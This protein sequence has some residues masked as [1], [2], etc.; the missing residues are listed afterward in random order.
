MGLSNLKKT[1][2]KREYIIILT[3]QR[4]RIGRLGSGGDRPGLPYG[5]AVI[6][7]AR[8]LLVTL[9]RR[10]LR[11]GVLNKK[12]MGK[13]MFPKL[14]CF[15]HYFKE[16]NLVTQQLAQSFWVWI[17]RANR[18]GLGVGGTGLGRVL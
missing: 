15:K 8:R 3:L 5:R 1:H 13:D 9:T 17:T 11:S 18:M 4:T 12:L 10:K 6:L 16:K 14:N 2:K 7:V